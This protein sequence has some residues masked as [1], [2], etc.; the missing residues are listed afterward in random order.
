MRIGF[1][2]LFLLFFGLLTAQQAP[3]N[4]A[5]IK[6]YADVMTN[7]SEAE[8]RMM[9]FHL[10]EES[11]NKYCKSEHFSLDSLSEVK[12]IKVFT[13]SDKKLVSYQVLN[14]ESRSK[15][16]TC[17]MDADGHMDKF[18]PSEELQDIEFEQLD[19]TDKWIEGLYYYVKPFY[20]KEKRD[21]AYLLFSYRQLNEYTKQKVVDVLYFEEGKPYLGNES[22][23]FPKEGSR[24]FVQ[25]RMIFSYSSDVVMSI[26]Y[27]EDKKRIVLDHLMEVKG[28]IPG[29]RSTQVPDGTYDAFSW[30][31]NTWR[32]I[33]LLYDD[34][35]A[36]KKEENKKTEKRDIFG[37]KQK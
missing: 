27:I 18:T 23:V 34:R 1:L 36:V 19:P 28:R 8:H 32:Y 21:T 17:I 7:A 15:S 35:K 33:D 6:F 31:G 22:F 26:A 9:S 11:L 16:V 24:D 30:D 25:N 20:Q 13:I 3:N 4:L 37:R 14:S 12:H 10:L 5:N 2:A 29:Q